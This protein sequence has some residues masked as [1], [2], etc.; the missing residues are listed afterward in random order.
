[1]LFPDLITQDCVAMHLRY[2]EIFND[3]FIANLLISLPVEELWKLVSIWQ[4]YRQ[5]TVA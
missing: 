5:G 2:G 4:S 1:L 3:N